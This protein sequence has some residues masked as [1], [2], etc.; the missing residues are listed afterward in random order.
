MQNGNVQPPGSR[1]PVGTG[2]GPG[3][4]DI[5]RLLHTLKIAARTFCSTASPSTT[6]PATSPQEPSSNWSDYFAGA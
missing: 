2:T 5:E 6:P 3:A 4:G 1:N